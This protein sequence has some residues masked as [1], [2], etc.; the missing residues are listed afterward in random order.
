VSDFGFDELGGL[1]PPLRMWA[2]PVEG[3][4][5]SLGVDTAE[6]LGHGDQS[7]VQVLRVDNGEQVACFCERIP[8][9]LIAVVAVRMARLYNGGLLVVEANNHGIAT[10]N[11]LRQ[12]GYRSVYRRRQVNRLYNRVTEEYGFKTT[13][14][15][16]PLIISGLDEALRNQEVIVRE[17]ETIIELKGYVRDEGGRMGGSPFDDRV[18]ALA[19]AHHGR[20][21]MHLRDSADAVVDDYMTWGWW[22]RLGRE[23]DDGKI[24]VG[25]HARRRPHGA[26]R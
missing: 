8:P 1:T 19:L 4:L 22:N 7:C 18:I 10:L 5:Y 25:R 15:T 11:A 21:Y 23:P 6:G 17:Q 3:K 13:R 14:T 26:L 20:A 12:F 16:K 2:D 24:V 9:D